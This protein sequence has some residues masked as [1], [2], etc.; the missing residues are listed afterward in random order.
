M[1][2]PQ[3]MSPRWPGCPPH[4]NRHLP[5]AGRCLPWSQRSN[6]SK[7]LPAGRSHN[8]A[9]RSGSHGRG[10]PTPAVRPAAHGASPGQGLCHGGLGSRGAAPRLIARG[11]VLRDHWRS[12]VGNPGVPGSHADGVDPDGHPARKRRSPRRERQAARQS[13]LLRPEEVPRGD[14][15]TGRATP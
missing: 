6:G 10:D 5:A 4:R 3:P 13:T 7:S 15:E 2:P 11:K 9:P 14:Q 12:Q 1:T 8:G